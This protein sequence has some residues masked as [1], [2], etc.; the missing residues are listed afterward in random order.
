M[1]LS[2][3]APLLALAGCL[4]TDT[5]SLRSIDFVSACVIDVAKADDDFAVGKPYREYKLAVTFESL[6]TDLYRYA[7]HTSYN[8]GTDASHCVNGRYDPNKM[9][10]AASD[11]FGVQGRVRYLPP[12][13]PPPGSP[14][15]PYHFYMSLSWGEDCQLNECIHAYDLV[16]KPEDVCFVLHG[17]H[18]MGP[19]FRSNTVVV[20]KAAIEAALAASHVDFGK[21]YS[22]NLHVYE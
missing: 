14:I 2:R 10:M 18:F 15:G 19:A 22:P 6:G 7:F 4:F 13:P 8:I 11:I 16:K 20:P 5:W 21:H 12:A 17:G 9:F 3:C 1:A